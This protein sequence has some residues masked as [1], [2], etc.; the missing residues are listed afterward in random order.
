MLTHHAVVNN[1]K[2]IGDRMDLSTADRMMIQVP[3]FHCFGMVLAMT[4]SM[5]HGTTLCP[6]PYFSARNA[7]ACIHQEHITAFHGVPTMFIAM[8][9][10]PDFA[11]TDFSHMRTGIMAGSVC[12]EPLMQRVVNDMH[13]TEI[14]ICYGLTEASPVM[15]QS[16]IHDPLSVRCETVGCAMP[17]IEVRVGDSE[18]CAELPRGQV[19]EI[20]C[21]G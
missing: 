20:L 14:T 8:L 2:C 4:A 5:T 19:G 16:D 11:K 18:T 9:N 3:M 10:H 17:G 15:T 13:M 7:L 12:P 21:R 1:G 6:L